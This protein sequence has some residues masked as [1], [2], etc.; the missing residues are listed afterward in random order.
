MKKL[1]LLIVCVLLIS[2]SQKENEE[3]A[4]LKVAVHS[5]DYKNSFIELYSEVNPETELVIDVVSE[6][7]IEKMITEQSIEY[8]VYWVEDAYVPLIIDDILELSKEVEVPINENY[9]GVFDLVKEA[10]QPIMATSDIYYA[11]DLDKIEEDQVSIDTFEDIFEL[12]KGFYYLDNSMFTSFFLTSNMNYFP[13]N[14][15]SRLN[16]MGESFKEALI[17]YRMIIDTIA[18]DDKKSYDNWFIKD[19]YYSGFITMDMQLEADEEIN[20]GHYQITKL[21]TIQEKQLYMQANSYGYVVNK[22]TK[23]PNASKNLVTFMHTKSAMQLLCNSNT[24]IPLIPSDI[25][26]EFTFENVHSKEKAYALDFAV[27]RNFVGI[28]SRNDSAINYLY[29]ESTVEKLK[30]CDLENIETCQKEL[31]EDYQEWLK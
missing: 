1:L 31:D 20:D 23:Y 9:I 5:E 24:Y 2:C 21:P 25:L 26:D 8:D 16:L 22:N 12:E 10:Y 28:E 14:E 29:E 27:G 4:V 3:E 30:A 15:T 7:E 19:T 18:C 13:G 17:D 11:L 6:E